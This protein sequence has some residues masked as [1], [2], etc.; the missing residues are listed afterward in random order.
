MN[1]NKGQDKK[2]STLQLSKSSS[3]RV[4]KMIQKFMLTTNTTELIGLTQ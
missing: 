2:L 1:M 3:Q 4:E